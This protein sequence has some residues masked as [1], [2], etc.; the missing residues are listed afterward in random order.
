MEGVCGVDAL[1]GSVVVFEGGWR[2]EVPFSRKVDI[3]GWVVDAV[4]GERQEGVGN[5]VYKTSFTATLDDVVAA[6]EKE[7]DRK[8]DR[9]EGSL[10]GAKKE[11]EERMKLGFFDGGVSLMS[12]VAV[13]D[14]E[15]RAWEGWKGDGKAESEGLSL[16]T[17]FEEEIRKVVRAVRNGEGGGGG[18]GC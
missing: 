6:V 8:F 11:A 14:K 13:W 18:C 17:D 1:W 2:G 4:L 7:L 9:Y 12:R 10:E 3:A 15:V 5:E 16:S